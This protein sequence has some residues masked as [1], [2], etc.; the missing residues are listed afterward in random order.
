[1]E[2]MEV[3]A[4]PD[5]GFWQGKRVLVTGHTG[6][7]GAW[8]TLWLHRMGASVAG[9]SLQ[10]NAS[11]SLFELASLDAMCD[12]RYC[13]IRDAPKLA[14]EI[15]SVDAE[16]VFHLAAQPLVLASYLDPLDTYSTNVMGTANVLNALRGKAS[17]H[18][19]Q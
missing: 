4:I 3:T 6:F 5:S 2:D 17:L 18:E 11:P 13:D 19:L 16:I 15:T 10:P 12:S 14:A 8:L 7:K 1:M 9:I